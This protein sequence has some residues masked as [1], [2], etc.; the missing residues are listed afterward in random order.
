MFDGWRE[1]VK[2]APHPLIR[3]ITIEKEIIVNEDINIK[4]STDV[5]I[6]IRL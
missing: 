3:F 1:D 2:K 6:D 4:S 5:S